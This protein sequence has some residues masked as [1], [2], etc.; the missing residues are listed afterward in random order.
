MAGASSRADS[1]KKKA[2]IEIIP[3][4]DVIFFL[5]ATFVLFTLSL[6]K[7]VSVPV[8]LPKATPPVPNQPVDESTV[9]IQVSD[10][11][12]YY[13]KVGARGVAEQI[14]AS[15]IAPKL[16][17]LRNSEAN[18]RVLVRGD[19]RAKFGPAVEVLDEVRKAGIEQVSV[20]TVPS[21]TGR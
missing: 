14:T 17:N 6:D 10:S 4:I 19:N 12:V 5:L 8:T 16:A 1:G 11:G 18:P 2:R 15:E 7:I 13:W 3:L 20:E 9:N 21:Q